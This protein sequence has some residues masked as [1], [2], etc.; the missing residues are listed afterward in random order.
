MFTEVDVFVCIVVLIFT[1]AGFFSGML[2][3][4]LALFGWVGAAFS[5]LIFYPYA[6]EHI[7]SGSLMS[8]MFAVLLVFIVSFIVIMVF[9][10]IILSA[11]KG[12][13]QGI[14]DRALGL[15]FGA[16]L[17]MAVVS[18][19]HF[20]VMMVT[21]EDPS[22]LQ[23]G[24][25]YEITKGGAHLLGN[26]LPGYDPDSKRFAKGEDDKDL[27]EIAPAAGDEIKEAVEE[28]FESFEDDE[29]FDFYDE[30]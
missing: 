4:F 28:G 17:G 10:A 19:L 2:K 1:F 22:W 25:T 11:L 23:R 8:N 29:F 15:I 7:G 6:T 18:T 24:K 20:G 9:N 5:T 27:G 26:V 16:V 12:W 3:T 13:S 21:E 14:M 30:E